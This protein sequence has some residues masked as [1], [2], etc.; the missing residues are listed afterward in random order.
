[1]EYEDVRERETNHYELSGGMHL[2]VIRKLR[3]KHHSE[4]VKMVIDLE[5]GSQQSKEAT[6]A[7]EEDVFGPNVSMQCTFN[8][9][10]K[11]R[12]QCGCP[13]CSYMLRYM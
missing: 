6:V 8:N 9:S 4:F 1:M 10:A 7:K 12:L 5:T 2:A 3:H 13:F 11:H